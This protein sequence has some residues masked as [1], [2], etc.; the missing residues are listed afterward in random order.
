[1]RFKGAL[2]VTALASS[3]A[4]IGLSAPA[5]RSDS[6]VPLA[7]PQLAGFH[8]ILVDDA[9]GYVFLS[10]G[11]EGNA[12]G[13]VVT[14]LSGNYVTTLDAGDGVQG[15]VLSSDGR[16]L[17]AALA[18]V[19]A[20]GVIDTASLTQTTTYSLAITGTAPYYLALQSGKLW[21]SYDVPA[22][23]IQVSYGAIGDFDLSAANPSFETQPGM[24]GA[25]SGYPGWFVAP[26]LAADPSDTGVLVAV[27][28]GGSPLAVTYR[29]TADPPTMLSWGTGVSGCG[30]RTL[31]VFPGGAQ[32]VDCATILNTTDLSG[33]ASDTSGETLAISPDG[34]LLAVGAGSLAA[35][36]A[37]VSQVRNGSSQGWPNIFSFASPETLAPAGLAFGASGSRLYA[38]LMNL[39]GTAYELQVIDNPGA[40]SSAL[41]LSAPTAVQVGSGYTVTGSLTLSTGSPVVGTP[42]TITRTQAGSPDTQFALTT[43]AR[44]RFSLADQPASAGTYTYS[45]E[46]AAYGLTAAA[47]T[48]TA[49]VHVDK[50]SPA[51][52]VT[53]TAST[54]GYGSTVKVTAHL[55]KTDTN[56]AVSLYA[57]ALGSNTQKLLASGQVNASGNLTVSYTATHNTRFTATFAGDE[58]YAATTAN[59][60][61]GVGV[62]VSTAISGYFATQNING[63]TYRVYH[64]TRPLHL[65]VA[66]APNKSGQC[67]KIAIQRYDTTTKAWLGYTTSACHALSKS[68]QLSTSV[69]LLKSPAALYRV[70]ADYIRPVTDNTNMSADGPWVYFKIVP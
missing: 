13:I 3:L 1:V 64:H 70:R 50:P 37:Q 5:A 65:G 29:V 34:S 47:S 8:Q 63:I 62:G 53:T 42:V 11:A 9:A 4:L 59:L 15:L 39:A 19:D 24:D 56:R 16:T 26:V 41:T 60:T 12:A 69:T 14:D 52:T 48:A 55:G 40:T 43:D 33:I 67:V 35:S 18:A 49:V 31:A 45:A 25:P 68:S 6:P 28:P 32:F 20:V 27:V 36:N 30:P 57:L 44:G 22:T 66:V 61:V 51:L 38:V 17:Y 23:D 58:Q 7:L 54:F 21:V 46:Y 2:L 10:E